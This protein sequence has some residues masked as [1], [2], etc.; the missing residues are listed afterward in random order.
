VFRNEQRLPRSLSLFLLDFLL[1]GTWGF[2]RCVNG[3]ETAGGHDSM[4]GQ[5]VSGVN[6]QLPAQIL[7]VALYMVNH[8]FQ[9][10]VEAIGLPD[11]FCLRVVIPPRNLPMYASR[12]CRFFR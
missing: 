1:I 6:S 3:P 11:F 9:I 2:Q 8:S 4:L 5:Y 7:R 12:S 10:H